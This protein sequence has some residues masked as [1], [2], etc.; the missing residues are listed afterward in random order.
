MPKK[1]GSPC[2]WLTREEPCPYHVTPEQHASERAK[3]HPEGGQG[4]EL[5]L[6]EPLA[7]LFLVGDPHAGTVIG[8]VGEVLDVCPSGQAAFPL[9]VLR[10][11]LD[12]LVEGFRTAPGRGGRARLRGGR[13]G[14]YGS[15]GLHPEFGEAALLLL[16]QSAE[17]TALCGRPPA[18]VLACHVTPGTMSARRAPPARRATAEYSHH[19]ER[20]N[21]H[22]GHG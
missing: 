12:A 22:T 21:R 17:V 1:D 15:R 2:G 9:D 16:V 4:G 8:P 20:P 7:A 11:G 5:V 3:L 13:A 19:H 6:A 14:P 10:E 18:D